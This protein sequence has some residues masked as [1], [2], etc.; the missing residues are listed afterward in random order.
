MRVRY[1]YLNNSQIIAAGKKR[2]EQSEKKSLESE[3]Y[4]SVNSFDQFFETEG[5]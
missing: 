2:D 5:N 1:P 3:I 4:R